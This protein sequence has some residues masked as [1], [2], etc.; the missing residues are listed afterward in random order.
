MFHTFI[1]NVFSLQI[2]RFETERNYLV[3]PYREKKDAQLKE[4]HNAPFLM[5]YLKKCTKV[6]SELERC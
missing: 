4:R 2:S 5:H 6:A 1:K 3:L